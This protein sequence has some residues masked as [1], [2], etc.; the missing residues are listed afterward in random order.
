L[1]KPTIQELSRFNLETYIKFMK[2]LRQLYRIV[3]FCQIPDDEGSYLILRHDIDINPTAALKMAKA[4]HNLGIKAT[5]FILLS[6]ENYNSFDGRNIAIIKQISKLGHEIGLHY[7]INKYEAYSKDY[8]SALKAE[9]QA[10]ESIVGKPVRCISSHAPKNPYGF[11]ELKDLK[12]ADDHELSDIYVHDSQRI[13]TIK[14][15]Q[16]LLNSPPKRVQLLIHPILWGKYTKR[17][18]RLNLLFVDLLLFLNRLRTIAIRILH[19]NESCD[20]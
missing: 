13:W 9:L 19:S 16:Y 7:D 6:S 1:N 3:P 10:L 2:Y 14:S 8:V 20:N 11:I 4:E 18:T 17:Q 5:Y 12:N 15:L